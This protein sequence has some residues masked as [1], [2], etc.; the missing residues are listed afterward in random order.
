MVRGS[1]LPLPADQVWLLMLRPATMLYVLRGLLDFPALR[2]RHRR[3]VE[4]ESGTGRIRLFHLVPFARWSIHVHTVEPGSRVIATEEC[5]A[6][7]RRWAHTLRVEPIDA[8]TCRYTDTVEVDAGALTP[9]AVPVVRAIFWH[10]HRRWRRLTTTIASIPADPPLPGEERR[11][12][13]IRRDR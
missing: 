12:S 2:D 3:I 1:V 10:R 8:T 13:S 4:G 7:F 11:P 5:G 6:M 9:V